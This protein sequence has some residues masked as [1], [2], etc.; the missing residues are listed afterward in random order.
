M[1]SE[2]DKIKTQANIG[3]T[4][5]DWAVVQQARAIKEIPQSEFLRE[6]VLKE[7]RRVVS[8]ERR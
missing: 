7:A 6:S 1:K 4:D 2:S 3:M 8:R 5:T